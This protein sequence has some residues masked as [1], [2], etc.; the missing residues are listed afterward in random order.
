MISIFHE[1]D[2]RIPI[3]FYSKIVLEL[4]QNFSKYSKR[5][6][7]IDLNLTNLRINIVKFQD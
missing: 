1:L 5:K 7:L 4:M 6:N 2:F 3:I